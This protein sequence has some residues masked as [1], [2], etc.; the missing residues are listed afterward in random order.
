VNLRQ[1]IIVPPVGSNITLGSVVYSSGQPSGFTL[2]NLALNAA[3]RELRVENLP[4][5]AGGVV[6]PGRQTVRT[7]E[8]EGMIVGADAD[9]VRAS[10]ALLQAALKDRGE[11]PV[12]IRW[13]ESGVSR[14]VEGYLDGTVEFTSTDSHFLRFR[15]T[16]VC[17][18]PIAYASTETTATIGTA[19]SNTGTADVW[20][21]FNVSMT[22]TV[23]SIR[24]GSTTTGEFV[25]LDDISGGSILEVDT[26]PGFEVVKIDNVS[27]MDKLAVATRF[28]A[29]LAGSNQFYVTVLAGGGTA[30]GTVTWR[31]GWSE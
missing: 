30:T 23:T 24:V 21:S 16:V 5:I 8:A 19:V 26:R 1:V 12:R 6:S 31:S 2:E 28:P 3:P 25:Q 14:E 13:T 4:L 27:V 18:D 9:A 11:N 29:M 7:V 17:A 10:R 22:G 20:P 15:F